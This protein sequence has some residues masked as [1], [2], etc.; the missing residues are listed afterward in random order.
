YKVRSNPGTHHH[1]PTGPSPFSQTSNP[2]GPE[3]LIYPALGAIMVFLPLVPN[4]S[5]WVLF[6]RSTPAARLVDLVPKDNVRFL[7]FGP[8]FQFWLAPSKIRA[9]SL[10]GTCQM[11]FC[12]SGSLD[13]SVS[14]DTTSPESSHSRW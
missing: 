3:G 8:I 1:F 4:S 13:L 10:L 6:L 12:F 2:V 9:T 7:S 5:T 11:G 14:R